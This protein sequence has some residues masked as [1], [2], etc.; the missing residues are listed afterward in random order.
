M[1]VHPV[2]KNW[3]LSGEVPETKTLQSAAGD[4][5]S[6]ISEDPAALLD[7]LFLEAVNAALNSTS[8]AE[9]HLYLR[10]YEIPQIVLFDLLIH[11]LPFVSLAHSTVN[12]QAAND[13]KGARHVIWMDI[14]AGRGIQIKNLIQELQLT[15]PDLKLLTII[16]IEPFREAL[17]TTCQTLRDLKL[18]VPFEISVYSFCAFAEN[19]DK[20]QLDAVIPRSADLFLVNSALT[21]HHIPEKQQREDTFRLLKTLGS[22]FIYLIEPDSD[23]YHEDWLIRTKHAYRHFKAVFNTID[24]LPLSPRDKNGLKLFFG[25]EIEDIAGKTNTLRFEKHEPAHRWK[26]YLEQAGYTAVPFNHYPM[27]PSPVSWLPLENGITG[28]GY[29]HTSVLAV[30]KAARNTF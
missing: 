5:R 8:L 13:S 11:Q 7:L 12:L 30:I 20:D 14:G 15:C 28:I 3:F 17:D 24:Q 21:L 9:H 6:R 1:T 18:S 27:C 16:A 4:C 25:R 26:H 23:H 10:Q 29:K 19:I 22:D 2:L